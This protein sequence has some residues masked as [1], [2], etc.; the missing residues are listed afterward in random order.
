MA[1]LSRPQLAR[2]PWDPNAPARRRAGRADRA[3]VRAPAGAG[4]RSA[5]P[6]SPTSSCARRRSGRSRC[7]PEIVRPGK[8]V[9]LLEASI[10]ADGVEVVGLGRCGSSAPRRAARRRRPRARRRRR[11]PTRDD[12]PSCNVPFRPM[13]ALRR[14]RDPLRRRRP[15]AR[16]RARP[17][18][19]C[20]ARSW[21]ARRPRACSTSPRPGDFGNGISATLSWDEYLFINPDLTLYIEREPVGEWICL[22][23]ETRIARRRDRARRERA[24]RPARPGRAGDPGPARRAALSAGDVRPARCSRSATGASWRR[25]WP[26]GRGTGTPRSA[27]RRR[28]CWRG[29]SSACPA[30]DG[31]ILA[32]PDLR[33]HPAGADRAGLGS[34]R[35]RPPGA[36]G[37]AARGRDAGR[38]GRGGPGPCAPR[39]RAL[40]GAH[41]SLGLGRPAARPRR[42]PDRR[43]SRACT[44][45]GSRPT[46]SR[47]ASSPAGSAAAPPRPGFASR[48]RWWAARRPRRSSA[49]PR[50]PTSA[51]ASARR[52]RGS[53]TCSSTPT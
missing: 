3:R 44:A 33:L 4:R 6:A 37:S 27:A 14:D 13:F 15:G 24:V 42:G 53:T 47:S 41:A 11:G 9:Q 34:G 1:D 49:S 20:A 43:A 35:G 52:S 23:S 18:F 25:S 28:R 38:R 12:P 7:G 29:R 39:S 46:R 26:A 16:G 5:W 22:E 8:R 31:L 45:R 19:A 36:P 51:P 2:G 32:P 48:V 21:P 10:V 40:A 50:P 17:G 30:P